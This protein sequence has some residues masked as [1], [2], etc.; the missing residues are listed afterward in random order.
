MGASY[1]T[2]VVNDQTNILFDVMTTFMI[3]CG[4]KVNAG[5]TI[6]VDGC[7]NVTITNIIQDQIIN[8]NV[9]CV[10]QAT[11]SKEF[12]TQ[13]QQAI[14]QMADAVNQAVSFN[15]SSTEASNTTNL[16]TNY[17]MTIKD[18][19]V[20][21]CLAN[22]TAQ[23]SISCK[24]AQNVTFNAIKQTQAIALARKCTMSDSDVVKAKLSIIQQISQSATATVKSI[25]SGFL[26]VILIILAIAAAVVFL[27]I[28][29]YGSVLRN[30]TN[31]LFL[32]GLLLIVLAITVIAFFFKWWPYKRVSDNDSDDQQAAYK[33]RNYIILAAAVGLMAVDGALLYFFYRGGKRLQLKGSRGKSADPT[34]AKRERNE[35][36]KEKKVVASA[37]KTVAAPKT[38]PAVAPAAAPAA[39][40]PPPAPPSLKAKGG[41][42]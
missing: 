7:S 10:Q 5:Q 37:T 11:A 14:K 21:K 2:N 4:T 25:L 3:D 15:P 24:N 9:E 1:S 33:K 40:A 29:S 39:A 19:F 42:A 18:K 17:A 41:G 35:K 27:F 38:P 34:P 28:Q 13:L 6:S 30:L 20:T 22:I 16:I 8:I 23:Q 36:Q 26:S 31:P 12:D 32:C